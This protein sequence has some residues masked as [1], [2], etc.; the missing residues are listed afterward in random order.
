MGGK[1]FPIQAAG[2]LIASRV[3]KYCP[4]YSLRKG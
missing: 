1:R 2:P 3:L 4:M